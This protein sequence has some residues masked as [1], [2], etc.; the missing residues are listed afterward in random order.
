ML[1]KIVIYHTTSGVRMIKHQ[2][3]LIWGMT[4]YNY[5][6]IYIIFIEYQSL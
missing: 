2:N 3:E 5:L 6:Q 4:H 1:I